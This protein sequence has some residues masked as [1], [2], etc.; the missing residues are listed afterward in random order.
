MNYKVEI[1]LY[2]E[3]HKSLNGSFFEQ[4]MNYVFESEGY[5]GL[6]SNVNFTG[7]ELDLYGRHKTRNEKL[8]VEC[9]AKVKPKSTEVKNFLCNVMVL[10]KADHGYFVYTQDLDHQAAGLVDDMQKD[11]KVSKKISFL[12]PDKIIDNLVDAKLIIPFDQ[13][14]IANDRVISDLTLAYTYYGI[15]YVVKTHKGTEKKEFHVFDATNHIGVDDNT[16]HSFKDEQVKTISQLRQ[17]LKSIDTHIHSPIETHFTSLLRSER[18]YIE[19]HEKFINFLGSIDTAL[20]KFTQRSVGFNE[21]FV[22]PNLRNLE[23]EF[24]AKDSNASLVLDLDTA[25][26]KYSKLAIFGSEVS[27]KSSI[28]KYLTQDIFLQNKIPILLNGKD[29]KRNIRPESLEQIAESK[30]KEQ[31]KSNLDYHSFPKDQIVFIIDDFHQSVDGMSKYWISLVENFESITSNIVLIGDYL[32]SLKLGLNGNKSRKLLFSNFHK[33]RILEFGPKLRTQ[34][35]EKWMS[36]TE[37]NYEDRNDH[38]QRL[39]KAKAHIQKIIGKNFVP[40]YAFYIISALQALEVGNINQS[41][42][43]IYGFYYEMLIKNA[44]SSALKDQ[45]DYNLYVNYLSHFAFLLFDLR[46]RSI[47]IPE[48]KEFHSKFCDKINYSFSYRDALTILTN[49]NLIVSDSELEIKFKEHYCFYYFI[50]SYLS[51]AL[52]KTKS[53]TFDIDQ[54]RAQ[55]I[56]QSLIE[57]VYRDE[58]ADIVMFL[59]HLSKDEFI[60]DCLLS[61]AKSIFKGYAPTELGKDVIDLNSLVDSL[62]EQILKS[63]KAEEVRKEILDEEESIENQVKELESMDNDIK[64]I[65]PLD[66]DVS[67]I[68]YFSKIVL[69]FKTLDLLGQIAKAYWGELEKGEKKVVVLETY[70]L[71]LRMLSSY[72]DAVQKS[73]DSIAEHVVSMVN[74]KQI[75]EHHTKEQRIKDNA[76]AF[77]FQLCH[78]VSYGITQRI[79]LAIGTDKL[80]KTYSLIIRENDVASVRLIDLAIKLNHDTKI[81]ITLVEQYYKDFKG[82]KIALLVLRNLVINHMYL[83]NTSLAIKNKICNLLGIKIQDQR[84]I[85]RTSTVKKK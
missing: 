30:F 85:S 26:D 78:L 22:L 45:R 2:P 69:A 12:G 70:H 20:S 61:N 62:P 51:K 24:G 47:S 63:I 35:I 73:G 52:T 5:K 53:S 54:H 7:L 82:N 14:V 48:F 10:K 55:E 68:D 36:I 23:L 41:N 56:I 38:Y 32:T 9:K 6:K 1:V 60:I 8:L 83:F 17:D 43:S 58:N 44:L 11:K 42:Y 16:I 31:Y 27:G 72:L 34:I 80:S 21:I 18:P 29:I 71:G 74:N 76:K 50:A 57:R 79:A 81:P 13:T 37:D 59:T 4:L 25:A 40:S 15:Y 67:S 77:I 33:F 3:L 75:R 19:F 49:S 46:Q 64:P 28:A 66:E 65:H 84:L 39:D